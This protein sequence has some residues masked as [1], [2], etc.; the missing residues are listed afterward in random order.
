MAGL[1]TGTVTFLF[2]DIEGSTR[3]L[4]QLGTDPYEPLQDQHAAILERAIADGGG[5]VVRIE[6]DAYFAVFPTPGGAL[7]AVVA[8]QRDLAAHPWP[9][10]A[11]IR[12]RM[13]LHS[14]EGRLGGGDYVGIDPNRAARIASAGHG[15]QVLIS[16]A[17]RALVEHDLPDGVTFRDLGTHRLKDIRHPEHLFDLVIDGLPSDFPALKTLDA[18]PN[19]LPLQLTSFVGRDAEIAQTIDLLREHRLVT[20][21]GPGGTGKTRLALAAG[22]ELLPSFSDG[23]F[24]VELAS[25]V[26]PGQ[27][28]PAIC[29]VLGVRGEPGRDVIDTMVNRLQG[30]DLLLILDNFEHL[31]EAAS[32]VEETLRRAAEVR[33]LATSRAP[34]GL[35]GEQELQ[36][37]PLALPDPGD[38][39]ELRALAGYE[40]VALFVDRAREARPGFEVTEENAAA[41]AEICTRLDGLPLAIELAASRINVL[42]PQAILSRLGRRLDLLTTGARNVPERQRTLRGAI[43]WSYDL[44]EKPE[45]RLF[46]RLSV[47]AGGADLDAAEPAC[48]PDGDLGMST[49]DGL[50][51]LVDKG[52]LRRDESEAGEPRFGMLE[53]ILEYARERL[54][55]DWDGDETRRRHADYFFALA[56]ASEADITAED[57][58][59]LDRLDREQDNLQAAL[60]WAIKNVEV[61]R[62]MVAAASIWRFWMFRGHLEVGRELVERLLAVPGERSE[63]RARGHGA[64]G[65][66][67]YWQQNVPEA[68]RHYDEQLAI[69]RELGDRGGIARALYDMAYLP[70]IREGGWEEAVRRLEEAAELFD[71]VGDRDKADKARGDVAYFRMLGGDVESA[72]PLMEQV[73][74]RAREKGDAFY[75]MDHLMRAAEAQLKLGRPDEARA[76]LLEGLDIVERGAMPGGV[77]AFLQALAGVET[78][79]GRHERSMRLYGAGQAINVEAGG[80]EDALWGVE[81][82]VAKAREAIGDEA[83]DRAL[84][85]GRAMTRV[86]AVAYA[87]S[88]GA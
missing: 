21:T 49:L 45:R 73:L 30:Q 59:G 74:A 13:G 3:L 80:G 81:D 66:L 86:E 2:T 23:V 88:D 71:E 14:G 32:M 40:A 87:R 60:R 76:R 16:D 58:A 50:S 38:L 39:P 10:D 27:V 70:Y 84:A 83:T 4:D 68:E 8:A 24:F 67:A 48:N 41:V 18:Q 28:C 62:G 85:E 5:T 69:Y 15:G 26:A 55:A 64:A 33:I 29:Q 17:T 82:P 44:L 63:A 11:A 19:N 35:Y 47:F 37:P 65:S 78:A 34:L 6:G 7:Q 46:A 20:L 51:S 72:L 52:L 22:N 9:E 25:L 36:V 42:S 1:P 31:L 57:P 43:D 54:D 79:Q 53:T 77:A 12:V 56:E 61:E 75:L